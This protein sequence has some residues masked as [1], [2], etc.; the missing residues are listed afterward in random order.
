MSTGIIDFKIPSK[1]FDLDVRGFEVL[2][3][4]LRG[5][6]LIELAVYKRHIA[7]ILLSKWNSISVFYLSNFHG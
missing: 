1:L 3:F 5:T 4:D 6:T 2:S 7:I